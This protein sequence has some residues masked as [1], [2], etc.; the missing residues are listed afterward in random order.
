MTVDFVISFMAEMFGYPC[1]Y[2]MNKID[3]AEYMCDNCAE[4]CEKYCN[5]C[6]EKECWKKF[7]KTVSEEN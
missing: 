3:I 7:L 1:N 5:H 2:S 6:S 4:W